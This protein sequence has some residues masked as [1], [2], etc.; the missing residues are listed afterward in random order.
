LADNN[1]SPD[2]QN[3]VN[4]YSRQVTDILQDLAYFQQRLRTRGLYALGNLDA[5]IV[6][7][8]RP[9]VGGIEDD[10]ENTLR[11]LSYQIWDLNLKG[12]LLPVAHVNGERIPIL[13]EAD[14]RVSYGGDLAR[15]AANRPDLQLSLVEPFEGLRAISNALT[16]FLSARWLWRSR[17]G[18]AGTPPVNTEVA[19]TQNGW[20]V[21][22]TPIYLF[23]RNGFGFPTSPVY[24]YVIPGV[25]YFGVQ[26]VN[27]RWDRATSWTI[28]AQIHVPSVTKVF[29]PKP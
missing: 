6:A 29:V 28:P 16:R 14:E 17:G 23:Q 12:L 7:R 9:I 25:Y 20:S 5:Q 19:N 4:R 8:I 18:G 2:E 1:L 21:V 26:Q 22:Y 3:F 15:V 24:G 13:L 11:L 10:I 27:V